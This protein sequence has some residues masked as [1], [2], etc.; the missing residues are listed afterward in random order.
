MALGFLFFLLGYLEVR[1]T[2]RRLERFLNLAVA[3]GIYFWE[4][5][6]EEGGLRLRMG[7][8]AFRQ[9]RP[10]V[11]KSRSRARIV[12]RR[13]LPFLVKRAVRRRVLLL[14]VAAVTAFLFVMS[15]F[16]W[17]VKVEGLKTVP[18]GRVLAALARLGLHPGAWK[19]RLDPEHIANT[20]PNQ[21]P[22]LAWAGVHFKGTRALVEVAERFTLPPARQPNDTPADV[23]AAKE[24]LI[25]HLLVLSGEGVVREGAT[26]RQ[27]DVLI[28]GRLSLGA[29][30]PAEG[31]ASPPRSV[32]AR[33]VVQARVWYDTY[34]EVPLAQEEVIPTGAAYSQRLLVVA[35]KGIL[36]SG[37][38]QAPYADWRMEE[39]VIRPPAWRNT[40]LP[41]EIVHRH[42]REVLRRKVQVSQ[43]EAVLRAEAEAKKRLLEQ[44]PPAA[45]ILRESARVVQKT[46]TMV[47]LRF[48]METEE[49]IG[50]AQSLAPPT[51]S[52]GVVG[53]GP[54]G[55]HAEDVDRPGTGQAN[56][57]YRR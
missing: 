18:E 6:Q 39:T 51:G 37:W 49:E 34:V 30:A 35:G 2:G 9:I 53:R 15:S 1:V 32:R 13:G 25:T 27:G 38:R 45:R 12:A 20:L 40:P 3:N 19:G 50:R 43:A 47:G 16:V 46:P 55:R 10:V 14:G 57:S 8:L 41:V 42:Y 28:R 36:L 22:E 33:G 48:L 7:L 5:R 29:E 21:V 17:F 31:Q 26:V 56:H 24:G 54:A 11:R 52:A 4:V 44:I 23:V